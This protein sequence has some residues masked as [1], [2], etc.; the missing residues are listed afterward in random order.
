MAIGKDK[1][2]IIITV[3][4]SV[5]AELVSISD[6]SG[7]ALSSICSQLLTEALP[8]LRM[9]RES[10]VLAKTNQAAAYDKLSALLASAQVMAG[11]GQLSILEEQDKLRRT[12]GKG[13]KRKDATT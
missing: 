13:R 9:M 2:R 11:E 4:Q 12:S 10:L 1:R 5:H 7:A 6:L 3:P 8:A